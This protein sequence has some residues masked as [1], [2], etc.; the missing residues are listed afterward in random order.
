MAIEKWVIAFDEDRWDGNNLGSFSSKEE[1]LEYIRKVSKDEILNEYE[2]EMGESFEH[3]IMQL[4]V[5]KIEE[6]VPS[7]DV[8]MIIDDISEKAAW[9]GQDYADGYLFNLEKEEEIELEDKL[10]EVLNEW[11]V[12]YKHQPRFYSILN[13][14]D[15]DKSLV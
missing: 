11:I 1:A 9:A 10:N 15:V 14:E 5:G 8:G 6:F 3:E 12:K 2:N 4:Y 7:I 13:I